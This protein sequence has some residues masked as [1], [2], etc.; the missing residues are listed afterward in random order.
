MSTGRIDWSEGGPNTD[1]PLYV[2][3]LQPAS[4]TMD[5]TQQP[6]VELFPGQAF[7]WTITMRN[8]TGATQSTAYDLL[9]TDTLPVGIITDTFT[10]PPTATYSVAGDEVI[11]GL[12][13][14]NPIDHDT[15]FRIWGHVPINQN[16]A[17]R[18]LENNVAIYRSSA[19]GPAE[20]EREWVPTDYYRGFIRNIDLAKDATT[21]VYLY[22]NALQA[23]AGEYITITVDVAIPQGLV[24]YDPVV[25]IL[26]RDG[27]TLTQVLGTTPWPDAIVLD[28]S[29]QDP[30]KPGGYWTQY[31]WNSLD[32]I[33]NTNTG[34]VTAEK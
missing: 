21:K 13:Y 22:N 4:F 3:L 30:A 17:H 29:I 16:L 10:L 2:T 9:I 19:P 11:F 15:I 28:P 1:A 26:L 20:G 12:P 14:L 8:P 33:T 7:S 25:H 5:K 6:T 27:M 32:S 23:V 18:E 34:P 31:E 24:V